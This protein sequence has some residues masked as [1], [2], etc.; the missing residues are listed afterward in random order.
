MDIGIVSDTSSNFTPASANKLGIHIVP[1]QIMI[2]NQT[3]KDGMEITLE[4]FYEKM[5]EA[6][7]LPTT[8]QPAIGEFVKKYRE[9]ENQYDHII[10]IHPSGELSG[11][12][13]TAQMA[14]NQVNPEKITVFDS[15]MVS[16]LTGYLTVE[17]KR[18]VDQGKS[19]DVILD[20]L[21]DMKDKTFAYV[22]L[23]N[24]DNLIQS[25]RLPHLAGKITQYAQI[26]PILK[27]SAKGIEL[28]RFVRTTNRAINKVEKMLQQSLQALDYP[29]KV[30]VAHGNIIEQAEQLKRSLLEKW[31]EQNS[32]IHRLSS[33]IGV[34]TGPEIIGFTATPDYTKA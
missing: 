27:I 19:V 18:L 8:S 22:V 14:A 10:S 2:D 21:E 31:P 9:I 23:D 30:D 25:G 15:K 26:K 24:M 6:D 34:H 33:V 11:T 3:Y 12:V 16:I 20:C 4:E 7:T 32:Q 1:M 5:A 28:K 13:R 29:M 17:A